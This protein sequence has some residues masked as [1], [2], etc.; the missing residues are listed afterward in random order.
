MLQTHG[1][2]DE[3]KKVKTSLLQA[4]EAHTVATGRGPHIT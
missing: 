2:L 4:M 3:V 1:R